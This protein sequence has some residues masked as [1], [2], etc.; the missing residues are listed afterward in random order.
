MKHITGYF[1]CGILLFAAVPGR[2]Q[3]ASPA[4][5]ASTPAPNGIKIIFKD[6]TIV[7][8]TSLRLAGDNVMATVQVGNGTGEIGYQV[9]NIVKIDFPEPP[10][11][12]TAT[13]LLE[14]GKDAEALGQLEPV[15]A[16]YLPFKDLPGNYWLPAARLK[17]KALV[18]LQRDREAEALVADIVKASSDPEAT[19]IAHLLIAENWARKG[20]HAKALAVYNEVINTSTNEETLARAWLNKGEVL[21]VLKEY[22]Y[23]LLACL[24]LPVFYPDQKLLMPQALLGCVRAYIGVDD[25]AD[26]GKAA[27]NLTEQFPNSPEATTAKKEMQKITKNSASGPVPAAGNP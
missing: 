11:I 7:S 14:Q 10:Q 23:A 3:T 18:D 25:A 4:Q 12:A 16:Y 9:E 24:H 20:D 17:L 26:A 6:G 5:P 21:L 1:F 13:G 15:E 19:R 8:T 27:Q 2:A 22:N